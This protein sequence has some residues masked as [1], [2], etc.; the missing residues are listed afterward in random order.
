MC[1]KREIIL[2][3]KYYKANSYEL[4]HLHQQILWSKNSCKFSE[5][6]PKNAGWFHFY[7]ILSREIIEPLSCEN[8]LNPFYSFQALY[9][10][11]DLH[12][13]QIFERSWNYS[14]RCQALKC[15]GQNGHECQQLACSCEVNR[16]RVSLL[17]A[18]S[19]FK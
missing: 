5:Y 1:W 2:G 9:P 18:F 13:A 3:E 16:L 6:H 10:L 19:W 11:S 17:L 7:V 4:M 15:F 12:C 8:E 14:P